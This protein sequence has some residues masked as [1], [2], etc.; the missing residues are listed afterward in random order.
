MVSVGEENRTSAPDTHHLKQK[1]KSYSN[2]DVNA[3]CSQSPSPLMTWALAAPLPPLSC[4]GGLLLPSPPQRDCG[5]AP[6]QDNK[7]QWEEGLWGGSFKVGTVQSGEPSL[8]SLTA[9]VMSLYR[10][11]AEAGQRGSRYHLWKCHCNLKSPA[12]PNSQ[13][14]KLFLQRHH[15]LEVSWGLSLRSTLHGQHAEKS[16]EASQNK[17]LLWGHLHCS[18]LLFCLLEQKGYWRRAVSL[19]PLVNDT[20][21][22]LNFII[23]ELNILGDTLFLPRRRQRHLVGKKTSRSV[24]KTAHT[25]TFMPCTNCESN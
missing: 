9:Q 25:G 12:V 15:V 23:W 6:L 18:F 20:L 2:L 11:A 21:N 19:A 10:P 13:L 8:S 17:T 22:Y 24:W 7:G 4:D 16:A 1:I 5:T 14:K 3:A